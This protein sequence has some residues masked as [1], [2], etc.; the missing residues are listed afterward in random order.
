M[1][2]KDIFCFA[3]SA[4]VIMSMGVS[5]LADEITIILIR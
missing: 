4:A 2:R 5:S 3:I 1:K